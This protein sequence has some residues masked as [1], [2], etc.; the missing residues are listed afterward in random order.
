MMRGLHV[1][2]IQTN[3]KEYWFD[4]NSHVF[5]EVPLRDMTNKVRVCCAKSC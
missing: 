1:G 5:H 3:G 4:E 2:G